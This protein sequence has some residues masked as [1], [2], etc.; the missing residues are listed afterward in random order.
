MAIAG[1]EAKSLDIQLEPNQA[2]VRQ[3]IICPPGKKI[4]GAGYTQ[5]HE[6]TLARRD[7]NRDNIAQ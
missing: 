1:Y 7:S 2:A 3:E 5:V 6:V 4:L